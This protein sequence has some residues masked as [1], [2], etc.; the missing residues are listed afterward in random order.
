MGFIK[1]GVQSVMPFS[2]SRVAEMAWIS[3]C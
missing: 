2:L 1:D 3:C